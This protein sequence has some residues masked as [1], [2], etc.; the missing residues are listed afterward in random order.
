M[1]RFLHF[2]LFIT[3][4]VKWAKLHIGLYNFKHLTTIINGRMNTLI[5]YQNIISAMCTV[6]AQFD[7]I[8]HI[9]EKK[10]VQNVIFSKG[11]VFISFKTSYCCKVC[12][13]ALKGSVLLRYCATWR[14]ATILQS[15][16]LLFIMM[17]GI[18]YMSFHFCAYLYLIASNLLLK[19]KAF[20]FVIFI[21]NVPSKVV[22]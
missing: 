17:I 8:N 4:K 6:E 5:I 15:S 12:H 10:K 14:I 7:S 11:I 13:F 2:I 18:D 19:W 21:T 9:Q 20:D 16:S 1:R 3:T 22:L